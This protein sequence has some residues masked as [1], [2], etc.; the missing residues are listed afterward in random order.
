L[1]VAQPL[2]DYLPYD[3]LVDTELEIHRIQIKTTSTQD[4][5]QPGRFT[6]TLRR[7]SDAPIYNA[8][9]VDF[10]GLVVL[11]VATIYIVPQSAM[12][13]RQKAHVYPENSDST[14]QFETYRENWGLL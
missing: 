13:D 3:L 1:H 10:F 14:G 7:S 5:H 8:D 11:P 2:G 12:A 9:N 6:F 4:T